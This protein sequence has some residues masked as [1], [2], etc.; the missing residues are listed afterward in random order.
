MAQLREQIEMAVHAGYLSHT[1]AEDALSLVDDY[2]D[3]ELVDVLEFIGLSGPEVNVILDELSTINQPPEPEPEPEPHSPA[4]RHRPSRVDP[5]RPRRA[6]TSEHRRPVT[7]RPSGVRNPGGRTPGGRPSGVRNPAPPGRRPTRNTGPAMR[8]PVTRQGLPRPRPTTKSRPSSLH[9]P[10]PNDA[11]EPRPPT[12]SLPRHSPSRPLPNP[13]RQSKTQLRPRHAPS[14][15]LPRPP[16]REF[17]RAT[18]PPPPVTPYEEDDYQP[19][20]E[21]QGYPDELPPEPRQRPSRIQAAPNPERRPPTRSLLGQDLHGQAPYQRQYNFPDEQAPEPEPPYEPGPEAQEYPHQQDS[22]DPEPIATEPDYDPPAPPEPP[23]EPPAEVQE[24]APYEAPPEPVDVEPPAPEVTEEPLEEPTPEPAPEPFEDSARVSAVPELPSKRKEQF[25][26]YEVVEEIGRGR[27]CRVLLGRHVK[28]RSKVAL[29]VPMAPPEDRKPSLRRMSSDIEILK[30]LDHPVIPKF[31]DEELETPT[32]YF[33]MTFAE[34]KEIQFTDPPN[35]TKA[36]ETIAISIAEAL[37]EAH[38]K[39]VVHLGLNGRCV[40]LAEDGSVKVL[41]FSHPTQER[42]DTDRVAYLAPEQ[43]AGVPVSAAADI[44]SF[45]VLLHVLLFQRLP[46]PGESAQEILDKLKADGVPAPSQA[47]CAGQPWHIIDA[48]V[49]ALDPNPETRPS[50]A[51]ILRILH[52][53]HK[54]NALF[55]KVVGIIVVLAGLTVAAIESGVF[56]KAKDPKAPST[57]GLSIGL[58]RAYVPRWR[59]R[60]PKD[61]HPEIKGLWRLRE[62]YV[63]TQTLPLNDPEISARERLR[64]VSPL[65]GGRVRLRRQGGLIVDYDTPSQLTDPEPW[66]VEVLQP[67]RFRSRHSRRDLQLVSFEDKSWGFSRAL[68][69]AVRLPIGRALWSGYQLELELRQAA[70]EHFRVE[71]APDVVIDFDGPRRRLSFGELS[72]PWTPGLGLVR[73]QLSPSAQLGKRLLINGRSAGKA[74]EQAL[75]GQAGKGQLAL[76]LKRGVLRIAKIHIEGLPLTGDLPVFA[77]ISGRVNWD[78]VFEFQ[79]NLDFDEGLGPKVAIFR[80]EYRRGRVEL[81]VRPRLFELSHNGRL[82]LAKKIKYEGGLFRFQYGGG[83]WRFRVEGQEDFWL[84]DGGMPAS[85]D[86]IFRLGAHGTVGFSELVLGKSSVTMP[87]TRNYFQGW[88]SLLQLTDVYAQN[89]EAWSEMGGK[90]KSQALASVT[91]FESFFKDESQVLAVSSRAQ[92]AY[93]CA[94][95]K[96]ERYKRSLLFPE[97]IQVLNTQY[98]QDQEPAMIAA[99]SRGLDLTDLEPEIALAAARLGSHASRSETAEWH[100]AMLEAQAKLRQEGAKDEREQALKTA[101]KVLD[102]VKDKSAAQKNAQLR[103]LI[104]LQDRAQLKDVLSQSQ[105]QCPTMTALSQAFLVQDQ[106]PAFKAQLWRALAAP[107]LSS[108]QWPLIESFVASLS[109]DDGQPESLEPLLMRVALALR[110][111]EHGQLVEACEKTA[112]ALRGWRSQERDQGKKA[113]YL[114]VLCYLEVVLGRAKSP[115]LLEA[116]K[117]IASNDFVRLA[118]ARLLAAEGKTA[119]AQGLLKLLAQSSSESSSLAQALIKV[120][121]ALWLGP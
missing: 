18:P 1:Q 64:S 120:D 73:L 94:L 61:L 98:Y 36:F 32:P 55:L 39:G 48:C 43:L 63:S 110:L 70:N 33:A 87:S 106:T 47:E 17:R 86:A 108:A 68:H 62:D 90:L 97:V 37:L 24:E 11:P 54:T 113:Q 100:L 83:R 9:T 121:P 80:V 52:K 85:G 5:S 72:V 44:W 107:D 27:T 91:L 25:G 59:Y 28:L 65:F 42:L 119:Q 117:S 22:Y 111:P 82:V 74:L 79:T 96:G 41:G 112:L 118:E 12:R 40:I 19:P 35:T 101:L 84:L 102:A 13:H 114:G 14:R 34:G 56:K 66:L 30:K 58:P 50:A 46:I 16:T 89:G 4:P 26:L 93:A 15:S 75:E 21:D 49:A 103:L 38:S 20:Y 51:Q 109:K 8:R 29:K 105:D 31:I 78:D 57:K 88:E 99:L 23:Y 6:P 92:M 2:P 53:K 77:R 81:R 67:W 7:G 69:S 115:L 45:G 60:K 116:R 104:H 10:S 3:A 76:V 71:L 95:A